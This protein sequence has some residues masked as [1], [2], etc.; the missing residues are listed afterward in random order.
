MN[1]KK[2]INEI[3]AQSKSQEVAQ[4]NNDSEQ[5][6][7]GQKETLEGFE[8]SVVITYNNKVEFQQCLQCLFLDLG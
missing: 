4:N 8:D 6:K 2:A 1:R 5:C 7:G 3:S